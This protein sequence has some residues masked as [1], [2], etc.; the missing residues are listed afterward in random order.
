MQRVAKRVSFKPASSQRE[1]IGGKQAVV[2]L[3][4]CLVRCMHFSRAAWESRDCGDCFN[5]RF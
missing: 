2:F 4:Y 5:G 3:N 1:T